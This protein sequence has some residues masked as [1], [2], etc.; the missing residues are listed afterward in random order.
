MSGGDYDGDYFQLLWNPA[1][2]NAVTCVPPAALPA[3]ALRDGT[4]DDGAMLHGTLTAPSPSSPSS[5]LS[6]SSSVQVPTT[7]AT[8]APT[9]NYPAAD[10]RRDG[11]ACGA[12]RKSSA[13]PEL[14]TQIQ[15]ALAHQFF[16]D[17]AAPVGL[18]ARA[19]LLWE[20]A[21]DTQGA[22]HPDALTLVAVYNRALDSPKAGG[23]ATIPAKL[24]AKYSDSFFAT[25]WASPELAGIEAALAA[26]E[27][28]LNGD[29]GN[30]RGSAV[31]AA[32]AGASGSILTLDPDLDVGGKSA[33]V[34]VKDAIA[35]R[36]AYNKELSSILEMTHGTKRTRQRE[37]DALLERHRVDFWDGQ[38][39]AYP[40]E[41]ICAKA[42]AYYFATY[43]A[44]R[45]QQTMQHSKQGTLEHRKKLGGERKAGHRKQP[46]KRHQPA[47]SF[48]WNVCGDVLNYVKAV[49]VNARSGGGGG[50]GKGRI[51]AVVANSRV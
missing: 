43:S 13:A 36:N 39:P 1:L 25:A 38:H 8:A 31:G 19:A 29:L 50:S 28:A 35:K 17:A 2:L 6:P 9:V 42:C 33:G 4:I 41:E 3:D 34:L 27:H 30:D 21:A 7:Q 10:G 16:E 23:S 44:A 26:G 37:I 45:D 14:A 22:G 51:P 48:C 47:L 46:F 11:G 32:G 12:D 49:K 15:A 24:E 5:P 20:A 18:V 40:T